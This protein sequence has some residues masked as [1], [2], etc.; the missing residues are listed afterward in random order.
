MTSQVERRKPVIGWSTEP[1]EVATVRFDH[2]LEDVRK[3]DQLAAIQHG[4]TEIT[5]DYVD[6][7]Q[8]AWEKAIR[9][10]FNRLEGMS[11]RKQVPVRVNIVVFGR[12]KSFEVPV[13]L[14]A[15]RP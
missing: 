6:P 3:A 11:K 12:E 2:D 5:D 10:R 9:Q 8:L 14:I 1:I 4:E 7:E 13:P 15:R